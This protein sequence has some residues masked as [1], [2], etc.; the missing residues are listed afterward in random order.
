[1]ETTIIHTYKEVQIMSVTLLPD[2]SCR[3]GDPWMYHKRDVINKMA[4]YHPFTIWDLVS[5]LYGETE[6]AS[7]APGSKLFVSKDCKTGRDTFRNSGYKIKLDPNDADAIV[8]PD[9]K[10]EYYHQMPCN[11]V[12][13]DEQNDDLYLISVRKNGYDKPQLTVEDYERVCNYLRN[14]MGLVPDEAQVRD[15]NVVFIPKCK[16]LQDVMQNNCLNVPYIQESKV[17]ITPS[18]TISPETLVFWENIDDKNLLVRTICTSDWNKY[19]IT[20]LAF[21][22]CQVNSPNWFTYA[23]NDFRRILQSLG[24]QPYSSLRH[25]IKD[26]F[27]SPQ[28]YDMLQRYIYFKLGIDEKGGVVDAKMF[29]TIHPDLVPFLQRRVALKPLEIPTQMKIAQLFNAIES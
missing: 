5:E 7:I 23:S 2:G 14:A 11:I 15:V 19:P 6:C 29:G 22:C 10:A 20:M 8:V 25:Y 26:K 24:Y 16:E 12:A 4:C 13:K 18:T 21:L 9:V 1:M 3:R 17:P 27:I 28:D